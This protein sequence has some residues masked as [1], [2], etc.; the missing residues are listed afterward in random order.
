MIAGTAPLPPSDRLEIYRRMYLW[1]LL[2]VLRED[3]PRVAEIL[4]D[5]A[6]RATATAYLGAHPSL[7]PSARHLGAGFADF[8][9]AHAADAPAVVADL[10]RLEWTRVEVFD[11]PDAP[12]LT[13]ADL[14]A[15][16][17]ERIAGLV[18]APVPAC[19]TLVADWP[20]H[21]V[22]KTPATAAGIAPARTALRVWRE[23]FTVYHAP[24]DAA[25]EA[26]WARL[27][28]GAPFADVCEAFA[29]AGHMES[30]DEAGR[31]AASLL[32]RWV[33]DGIL[34]RPAAG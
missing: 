24:M 31:A 20:V 17:A 23:G 1:R 30:D 18:L 19:A 6:F 26:A 15:L 29:T 28:A 8:V 32:A 4:G 11:A 21:E 5:D 12:A 10:A 7:H 3:Y 13:V 2:D 9:A 27:A 33:D 25:E 16:D 34:A 22:W 14:G